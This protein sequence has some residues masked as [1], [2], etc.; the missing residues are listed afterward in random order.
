MSQDAHSLLARLE[1]RFNKGDISAHD[2]K[3]E[4][5]NILQGL[6]RQR[7]T[8]KPIFRD[9][10]K[11]KLQDS[12]N[13]WFNYIPPSPFVFG[14]DNEYAELKAGIYM[15][16]YPVTVREFQIFLENSDWDYPE[17]DLKKMALVSPDPNCPVSHVS[18]NDAKEYCRWLRKETKEYYSLPNEYEWEIAARGIDGRLYPWGY[19]QPDSDSACFQGEKRYHGTVPVD[20]F[21]DNQS[22]FGCIGMAGNVWEWCLDGLDDPRDPHILRGGSWRNGVEHATCISQSYGYPP[23]KRIDYGGF[24]VIYLPEGMLQEYRQN[25]DDDVEA[26]KK[27]SQTVD[28]SLETAEIPSNVPR[29]P[30]TSPSQNHS[31]GHIRQKV[32]PNDLVV[33]PPPSRSST[34]KSESVQE[35]SHDDVLPPSE[36]ETIATDKKTLERITSPEP[37]VVKH[38]VQE[39]QP[40]PGAASYDDLVFDESEPQSSKKSSATLKSDRTAK[41]KL[42]DN[43]D[44]SK[45]ETEGP[46]ILPQKHQ[47]K[48]ANKLKEKAKNQESPNDIQASINEIISAGDNVQTLHQQTRKSVLYAAY[49]LWSLL[50]LSVVVLFAYKVLNL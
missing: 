8:I 31:N 29:A 49:G 19:T 2:Y 32:K 38:L 10:R 35:L 46:S 4:K 44:A 6:H 28:R 24:R 7:E 12:R 42:P 25:M 43:L 18:W 11:R 21:P 15:A 48:S 37:E 16:T 17:S 34:E 45:H 3:R 14:P 5:W 50:F 30:T 23:E 22:P 26:P 33:I 40:S 41:E 20:S 13:V 1:I 36:L 47:V 9:Q 27:R 39:R